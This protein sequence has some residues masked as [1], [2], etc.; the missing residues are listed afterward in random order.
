MSA[1]LARARAGQG[2]SLIEAR[3]VRFLG[4]FEGDPQGYRSRGEVDAGRERDPIARLRAHLE[5][6]GL[7]DRAHAD[8]VAQAV[9]LEIQDA[10]DFA[11]SSPLPAPA[12]ALE[13][14]FVHYPW[15]D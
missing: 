12:D 8:R 14:L 4:H 6:S 11:E 3:T 7:L 9:E 10:V 2:P 15:P 13:D 1:S 5:D